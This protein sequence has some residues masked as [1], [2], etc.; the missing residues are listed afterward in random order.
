MSSP[1]AVHVRLISP[2]PP[3][4][5]ARSLTAAG[6]VVSVLSTE[7]V[8]LVEGVEPPWPSI[9]VTRTI[10]LDSIAAI[11]IESAMVSQVVLHDPAEQTVPSAS[12]VAIR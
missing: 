3:V 6:A 7:K 11:P 2:A 4:A 8:A 12:P 5:A 9:A 10:T 1:T